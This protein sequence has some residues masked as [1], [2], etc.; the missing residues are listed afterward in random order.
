MR[1]TVNLDENLLAL[2]KRRAAARN[3]TLGEFVE[4]AVRRELISEVASRAPISL[5]IFTRGT[6]IRPGIDGSS[7]RA[8]FD[9][10]DDDDDGELK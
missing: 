8:L 5:P 6:G 7:N 4:Q 9:A 10:L 2:A 3:L 1:T